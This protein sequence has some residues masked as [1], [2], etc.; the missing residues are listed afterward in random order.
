MLTP[1][2][3]YLNGCKIYGGGGGLR[4]FTL[5][6]KLWEAEVFFISSFFREWDSGK[7]VSQDADITVIILL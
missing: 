1:S 2:T 4:A 5:Q 3:T 6:I 7:N